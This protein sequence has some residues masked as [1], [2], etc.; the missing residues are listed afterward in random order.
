MVVSEGVD[1]FFHGVI[2]CPH[3]IIFFTG[4]ADPERVLDLVYFFRDFVFNFLFGNQM[5]GAVTEGT[6]SEEEGFIRRDLL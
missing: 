2:V 5:E 4:G 1:S 6:T 3:P